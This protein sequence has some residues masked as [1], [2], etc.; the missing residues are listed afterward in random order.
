MLSLAI[1]SSTGMVGVALGRGDDLI[2]H[3]HA[4]TDRRHAEELTPM[5]A[6]VL[7]E[8]GVTVGDLERIVVDVGPGRFTGLRVG[9][10]TARTLAFATG[11][12]VVPVTSLASLAADAAVRSDAADTDASGVLAVVDARRAEVF[13]QRFVGGAATAPARS[14][15]PSE[16][17]ALAEPGDV[18]CGDGADRYADDFAGASVLAD[19]TLLAG[20]EPS[21]ATML[22]LAGDDPGRPGPEV[23]PAYLRDPDVQINIKTR[24]SPPK[25]RRP[26]RRSS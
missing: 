2:A 5:L 11:V 12:G 24:H 10:A 1:T 3:R 17:A 16:A 14:L 15:S 20:L 25:P 26:R 21:A 7:D 8:G 23:E 18:I 19:A 22:R 6:A 9:V 4:A 13:V